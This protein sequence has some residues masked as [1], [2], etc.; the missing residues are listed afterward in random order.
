MTYRFTIEVYAVE[1]KICI[2]AAR[3]KSNIKREGDNE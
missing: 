2:S 3:A 1:L